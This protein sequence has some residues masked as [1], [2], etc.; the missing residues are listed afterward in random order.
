L[1]NQTSSM[2]FHYYLIALLLIISCKKKDPN[3]DLC[4]GNNLSVTGNAEDHIVT[5]SGSGG[6]VPY[7][8]SMDGVNFN[9]SNTFP[10]I[11]NGVYTVYVKDYKGCIRSDEVLVEDPVNSFRDSR[12]NKLYKTTTIGNQVWMAKNLNFSDLATCFD[13]EPS[14]CEKYGGLYNFQIA[15]TVC[16][17]GFHLPSEAEWDI[18]VNGLGGYSN[19][20]DK[21]KS[22][23]ETSFEALIGS[24]GYNPS[25]L[26][27]VFINE[28]LSH[29]WT[30]TS[31]NDNEAYIITLSSSNDIVKSYGPKSNGISVRC[32]KD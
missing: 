10:E 12:D 22:D 16:P 1:H 27:N 5:I 19:N 29:F 21:I 14:N 20:A 11:E 7:T 23:G 18:L 3:P 8:Y 17:T 25:N 15:T 2:K 24:G 4:A 26:S 32:I 28:N 13:N 6:R 30:S 31:V 9:D